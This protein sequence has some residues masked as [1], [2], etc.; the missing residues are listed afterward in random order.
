[1]TAAKTLTLSSSQSTTQTLTIPNITAS[2]TLATLGLSQTFSAAT[3]FSASGT[4]LTVSNTASI[5]TLTLSNALGVTYG[6]TGTTTAPTQ[7]GVIYASSTSAYASTAA[8]TANYVLTAN[9][10][11]APTFQQLSLTAGVTGTLPVANGGTGD[12]SFTAYAPIIGGTTTTGAL[13]SASSGMSN[14]GY[15]LTSTGSSSA[16]T[17]QAAGNGTVT[18]VTFTGDGTVLS[19]TPSS[20]VTSSGTLTASLNTQSANKVLAG[21]S[22]GS[23][24]NPTFRA[25]VPADI[26][27]GFV[28]RNFLINA[29]GGYWQRGTSTTV[30]NAAGAYQADRFYAWNSLGS[31]GVLT[32]AQHS[33]SLSQS[34][35]AFDVHVS[36]A[37]TSAVAYGINWGQ[38]LDNPTSMRLYNQP[39]SLSMQIK[40]QGNVNQVTIALGYVTSEAKFG[41]TSGLPTTIISS[42]T[43][44]VSTSVFTLGALNNVSMGTSVTSSGSYFVVCYAS[45]VS[46]GHISDLNNGFYIEQPMLNLGAVAAPFATAGA[47]AAEELAMCQRYY[48]KS[49]DPATAPGTSTNQGMYHPLAINSSNFYYQSVTF[50]VTKRAVPTMTAYGQTGTAGEWYDINAAGYSGNVGFSFTGTGQFD[51][52]CNNSGMTTNHF[53]GEHWTADA[54]I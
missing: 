1:M 48:E 26:P 37:P 24:A 27:A 7:Y 29:D 19:S 25:L 4:A 16:P 3:T 49:Y 50:K 2:D 31:A 33:A 6:G 28:A 54:D 10:G 52:S 5:G 11:S 23:A 43:V 17:W 18:S 21:P 8:G 9:S 34:I 12:T 38:S 35:Y 15:V 47:N 44:S 32:Y 40:A 39:A 45:G 41:I 13:Q 30:A 20:A 36:T 46:S 51:W 53:Q 42:Q 22:S 14:S